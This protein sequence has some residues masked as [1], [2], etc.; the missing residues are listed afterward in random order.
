MIKR[1]DKCDLNFK[2]NTVSVIKVTSSEVSVSPAHTGN[3]HTLRD[4]DTD[5]L[6]SRD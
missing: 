1:K 3:D 5:T 2:M 6:S 4:T